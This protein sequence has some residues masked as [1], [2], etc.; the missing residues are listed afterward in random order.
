LHCISTRN[1]T[2]CSEVMEWMFEEPIDTIVELIQGQ[3]QQVEAK[4]YRV[5]VRA[6]H[7]MR[8]ATCQWLTAVEC[9]PSRRLWRI[10]VL[11]TR[12][13]GVF[14]IETYRVAPT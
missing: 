13:D 10:A 4:G 6:V 5:K 1:L 11:A 12:I 7:I 9:F 14:E 8:S 3:R 2:T